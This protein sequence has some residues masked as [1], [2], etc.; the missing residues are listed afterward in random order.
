MKCIAEVYRMKSSRVLAK[1]KLER[2]LPPYYMQL[3]IHHWGS[4]ESGEVEPLTGLKEA[5]WRPSKIQNY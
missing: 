1:S 2:V 4:R 5:V 3:G